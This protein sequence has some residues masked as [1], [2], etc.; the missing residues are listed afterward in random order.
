MDMPTTFGTVLY[1]PAVWYQTAQPSTIS[2]MSPTPIRTNRPVNADR[3]R[4]IADESSGGPWRSSAPTS[5][6]G[7]M[8]V[9]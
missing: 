1:C 3:I 2:A 6:D 7:S 5:P 4:F 9:W 8:A